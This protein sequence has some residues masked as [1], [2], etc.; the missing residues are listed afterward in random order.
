MLISKVLLAADIIAI[1][2]IIV[3]ILMDFIWL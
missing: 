3:I 2:Y 1:I